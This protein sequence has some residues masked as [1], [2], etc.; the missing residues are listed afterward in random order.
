MIKY[1]TLDEVKNIYG[2]DNLVCIVNIKQI[3]AYVKHS[4]Q[5]VWVD[6][7]FDGKIICYFLK[8]ESKELFQKWRNFELGD[9]K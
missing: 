2:E 3:L 9:K 6:E 1:K 7:G 5:P 8:N 4:L